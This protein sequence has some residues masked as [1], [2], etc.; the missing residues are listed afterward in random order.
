VKASNGHEPRP[1]E[2]RSLQHV[3]D[4]AQPVNTIKLA[5]GVLLLA[6]VLA[7]CP[8]VQACGY[9][10]PSSINLGMLNW[11]YPDALHVRTAVWMAQRDGALS[12]DDPPAASSPQTATMS[13][14]RHLHAVSMKLALFRHRLGATLDG[15]PIPSFSMVFIGAMFWVR[16]EQSG[17]RLEMTPH[18]S[19]PAS[20]DAVIVTD[21]PVVTALLDGRITPQEARQRGLVQFYNVPEN[22]KSIESLLDRVA[23]LGATEMSQHSQAPEEN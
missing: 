3:I 1:R 5:R 17:T 18:A 7:G 4:A 21:E 13:A 20:E 8:V 23:P 15:R 22:M 6:T 19:G 9:H 16:F 2:A 12:R 11:S 14:M 10:D